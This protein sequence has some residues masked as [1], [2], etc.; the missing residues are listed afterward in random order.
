MVL[1]GEIQGLTD[2]YLLFTG[3]RLSRWP[4]AFGCVIRG[5]AP[6]GVVR[7]CDG[8]RILVE[9]LGQTGFWEVTAKSIPDTAHICHMLSHF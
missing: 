1:H 5:L 6:A 7:L 4:P 2:G 9:R 3:C 8:V